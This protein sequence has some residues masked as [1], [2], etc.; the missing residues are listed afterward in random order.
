M[1]LLEGSPVPWILRR[2]GMLPILIPQGGAS[3][4]HWQRIDELVDR[5]LQVLHILHG[6][7]PHKGREL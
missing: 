6:R 7:F 5:N 1:G 4:V 2:I 3:A